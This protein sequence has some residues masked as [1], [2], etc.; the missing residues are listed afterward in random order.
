MA[1]EGTKKEQEHRD[2]TQNPEQGHQPGKQEDPAW[3][4]NKPDKYDENQGGGLPPVEQAGKHG[5]QNQPQ[6]GQQQNPGGQ[7][8]QKSNPEHQGGKRPG[9]TGG[10]ERGNDRGEGH[11][12]SSQ[13]I[14]VQDR[15]RN[16]GSQEADE[17]GVKQGQK[18]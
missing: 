7:Q 4:R 9:D 18:H 2:P 17:R 6:G 15:D 14:D 5:S 3:T 8:G 1:G 13:K 11:Q 12:D 10:S 16:K